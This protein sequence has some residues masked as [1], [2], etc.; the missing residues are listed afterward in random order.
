MKPIYVVLNEKAR[1]WF[2]KEYHMPYGYGNAN[3][4]S[5]REDV[6]ISFLCNNGLSLDCY[7][8]EKVTEDGREIIYRGGTF[9]ASIYS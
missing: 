5:E 8:V 2:E 9:D 3:F 6:A 4:I 1:T 7:V